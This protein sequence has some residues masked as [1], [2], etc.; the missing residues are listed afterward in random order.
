MRANKVRV[1]DSVWDDE[2]I[3]NFLN[4]PSMGQETEDC[5]RLLFAYRSM[6]R[7]DCK[8]SVGAFVT[9]DGEV[10]R[11]SIDGLTRAPEIKMHLKSAAFINTSEYCS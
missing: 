5:R 6:R 11:K 10:N 1:T 4:R 9:T 3:Q 7:G 2:R 8:R